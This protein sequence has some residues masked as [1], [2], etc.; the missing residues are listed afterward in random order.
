MYKQLIDKKDTV[1]LQEV[2]VQ[3]CKAIQLMQLEEKERVQLPGGHDGQPG[4]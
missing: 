2:M 1:E 3:W 4:E